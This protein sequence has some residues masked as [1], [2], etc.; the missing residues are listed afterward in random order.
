M[1]IENEAHACLRFGVVSRSMSS[2][3]T[4]VAPKRRPSGRERRH[5][6]R[7]I[8]FSFEAD[9]GQLRQ[10]DVAVARCDAV[11]EAA[12]RLEQVR[13][14]LI[15]AEAEAGGDHERHL[16]TAMRDDAPP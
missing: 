4:T 7:E 10:R 11:R 8:A 2:M 9:A 13:I 5:L 16:V 3:P 1:G 15:A 12:V 6:A 14:A